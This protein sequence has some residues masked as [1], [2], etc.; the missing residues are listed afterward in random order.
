MIIDCGLP[1]R[2]MDAGEI[3]KDGSGLPP[4][5]KRGT[6]RVIKR[7]AIKVRAATARRSLYIPVVACVHVAWPP[8]QCIFRSLPRQL[9]SRRRIFVLGNATVSLAIFVVRFYVLVPNPN[10]RIL[11]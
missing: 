11:F 4:G 7:S 9:L 3:P 6:I 10:R 5:G 8:R 2:P 1:Y